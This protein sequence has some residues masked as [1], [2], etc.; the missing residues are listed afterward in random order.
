M[1]DILFSK[2]QNFSNCVLYYILLKLNLM[3]PRIKYSLQLLKTYTTN[4]T[5][6]V[7]SVPESMT[8]QTILILKLQVFLT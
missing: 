5:T 7:I 2:D 8:N 6:E 1:N 4:V 3:K